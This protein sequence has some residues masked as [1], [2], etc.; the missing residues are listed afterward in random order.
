MFE[1]RQGTSCKHRGH[2]IGRERQRRRR[3][4]Q[5]RPLIFAFLIVTMLPVEGEIGGR[6]AKKRVMILLSHPW[7][8]TW[9]AT[10]L[11]IRNCLWRVQQ[12]EGLGPRWFRGVQRYS[13][14]RSGLC[15]GRRRGRLIK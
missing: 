15:A 10:K 8:G 3:S 13:W 4:S 9:H 12:L 11:E 6:S 1:C 14:E 5:E 2:K 7:W